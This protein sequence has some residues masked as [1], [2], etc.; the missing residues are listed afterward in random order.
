VSAVVVMVVQPGERNVFDQKF[1]EYTLW[2]SFG[3]RTI[4]CT[5]SELAKAAIVND[6]L[7]M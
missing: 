3:V 7:R 2:N 5:L 4:R 6:R 1:N